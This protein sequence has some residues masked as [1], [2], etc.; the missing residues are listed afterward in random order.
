ML[1]QP[2]QT[3]HQGEIFLGGEAQFAGKFEED[4]RSHFLEGQP[5]VRQ[6]DIYDPLIFGAALTFDIA[7]RF[8][9]LEER[10]ERPRIEMEKIANLFDRAC[11]PFPENQQD[12]ILGLGDA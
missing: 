3:R 7:S 2:F 8:Q 5:G 11:A 4:R 1:C 10:R 12:Q 9:A 6:R